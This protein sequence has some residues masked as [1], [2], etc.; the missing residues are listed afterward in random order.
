MIAILQCGKEPFLRRFAFAG[1]ISIS[2]NEGRFI[3]AEGNLIWLHGMGFHAIQALPFIGLL[4]AGSAL[5]TA[6]RRKL[7]HVAGITFFLGLLA[8]GWQTL[9]GRPLLEWSALPLAAAAC[10][11]LVTAAGARALFAERL[12][13]QPRDKGIPAQFLQ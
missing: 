12:R 9:L 13:S 5:P 11:I 10:F 6:F 8:M 1:G 3:G 7:I 4:A 2:M